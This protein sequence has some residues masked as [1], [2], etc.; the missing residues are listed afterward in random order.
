MHDNTFARPPM[1]FAKNQVPRNNQ[2][3]T[4]ITSAAR[5]CQQNTNVLWPQPGTPEAACNC[6][7]YGVQDVGGEIADGDDALEYCG[8]RLTGRS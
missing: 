7:V 2:G 8:R 1:P 3:D 4:I 5:G 6:R